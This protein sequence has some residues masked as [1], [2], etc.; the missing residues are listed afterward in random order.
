[1]VV[2]EKTFGRSGFRSRSAGE[3]GG[4]LPPGTNFSTWRQPAVMAKRFGRS[5]SFSIRQ[6]NVAN[7]FRRNRRPANG[8]PFEF[9]CATVED[10]SLA[11]YTSSRGL[12]CDLGTIMFHSCTEYCTCPCVSPVSKYVPH[13]GYGRGHCYRRPHRCC[14]GLVG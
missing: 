12:R 6:L 4:S 8:T 10:H 3:L 2:M 14:G 11:Y 1:M 7:V 9:G 5:W 13:A